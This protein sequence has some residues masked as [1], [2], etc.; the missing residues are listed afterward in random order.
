V[1]TTQVLP[2]YIRISQKILRKTARYSRVGEIEL[3]EGLDRLLL[4]VSCPMH[5]WNWPR[6]NNEERFEGYDAHQTCHKCNSHR[7]FT[8]REWHSGPV[9][10]RLPKSAK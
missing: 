6:S 5:A 7:F 9:Y 3:V 2:I 4:M 10:R 1:A 8:T